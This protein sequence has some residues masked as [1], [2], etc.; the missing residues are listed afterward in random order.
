MN[1]NTYD[2]YEINVL[3]NLLNFTKWTIFAIEIFSS[4]PEFTGA[5][6]TMVYFGYQNQGAMNF[7]FTDTNL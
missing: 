5:E 2:A 4:S 1:N 6:A 7:L 3:S